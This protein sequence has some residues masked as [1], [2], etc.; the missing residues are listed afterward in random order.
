MYCLR[1][2]RECQRFE[3]RNLTGNPR[4]S[5]I[6]DLITATKSTR[7]L[8]HVSETGN[9]E[10]GLFVL[11]LLLFVDITLAFAV[12]IPCKPESAIAI[13]QPVLVMH[14]EKTTSASHGWSA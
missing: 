14:F 2:P 6:L 3:V 9:F 8:L 11:E 7:L 4:Q 10:Q 1:V 5:W 12:T 13:Y